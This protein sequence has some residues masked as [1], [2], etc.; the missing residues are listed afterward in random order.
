MTARDGAQAHANAAIRFGA[1]ALGAVALCEHGNVTELGTPIGKVGD[2]LGAQVE[3]FRRD[4]GRLNDLAGIA[5]E[6]HVNT[7]IAARHLG[8]PHI[9]AVDVEDELG[10]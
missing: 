10:P 6:G 8:A 3:R 9:I 7:G 1:D 4:E 2:Q 5:T